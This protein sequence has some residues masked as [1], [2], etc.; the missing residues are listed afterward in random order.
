MPIKISGNI[1][2]KLTRIGKFNTVAQRVALGSTMLLF[3][4]LIDLNN[5]NV[6]EKTR[7]ISAS[8]SFSR[9]IVGTLAGVGVRLGCFA[10]GALLSKKG[11][12]FYIEALKKATPDEYNN[13]T[14]LI[15]NILSCGALVVANFIIDMPGINAM[16]N[17][18]NEKFWKITPETSAKKEGK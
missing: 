8:R 3:Q 12:P 5:K 13:Y 9:A 6:D 14:K 2:D 16:S 17:F 1:C 10:L 18:I 7:K 15:G 4:P 11:R